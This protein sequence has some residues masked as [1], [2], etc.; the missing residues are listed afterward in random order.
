MTVRVATV[1]Q[2]TV[3]LNPIIAAQKSTFVHFLKIWKERE[4]ILYELN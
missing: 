3:V 2:R 1:C 4:L